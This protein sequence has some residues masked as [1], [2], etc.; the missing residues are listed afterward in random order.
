MIVPWVSFGNVPP[1][2]KIASVLRLGTFREERIRCVW[3]GGLRFEIVCVC[4]CAFGAT[5]LSTKVLLR[6]MPTIYIYTSTMCIYICNYVIMCVCMYVCII[7]VYTCVCI[8]IYININVLHTGTFNW[9]RNVGALS[10]LLVQNSRLWSPVRFGIWG[11]GLWCATFL[12]PTQQ[13]WQK[14]RARWLAK[15]GSGD[16]GGCVSI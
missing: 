5:K 10:L 15:P 11:L 4:V 12:R 9:K 6:V 8:Y 2:K 16:P 14:P 7:Y 3:V 13:R 1:Q